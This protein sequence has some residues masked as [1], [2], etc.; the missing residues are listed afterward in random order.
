MRFVVWR[1]A[2]RVLPCA[3]FGD[4]AQFEYSGFYFM[5]CG[6]GDCANWRVFRHHAADSRCGA[7]IAAEQHRRGRVVLRLVAGNRRAERG[8]FGGRLTMRGSLKTS[9][10]RFSEAK[11]VA[12]RPAV[13][14]Y[15]N[16]GAADAG[17]ARDDFGIARRFHHLKL[18]TTACARAAVA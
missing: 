9:E 11:N 8:V 13:A 12:Q 5:E 16:A 15:C 18:G 17:C 3:G 2:G 1:R 7:R 10:A 4:D 6:R 14:A